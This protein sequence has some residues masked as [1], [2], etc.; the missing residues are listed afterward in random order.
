[1]RLPSNI[2]TI[3]GTFVI[4]LIIDAILILLLRFC[5]DSFNY[6]QHFVA[7]SVS[8][9]QYEFN[10]QSQLSFLVC[11]MWFQCRVDL[12]WPTAKEFQYYL[13]FQVLLPINQW[14]TIRH[15]PW[16]RKTFRLCEFADKISIQLYEHIKFV[17]ILFVSVKSIESIV[18][19]LCEL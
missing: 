12:S 9:W 19:Q 8:L 15:F 7:R 11:L 2:F 3:C 13:S 14:F 5:R 4:Y 6:L 18:K 17:G 10:R 1:M 16:S